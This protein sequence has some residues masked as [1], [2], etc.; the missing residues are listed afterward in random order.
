MIETDEEECGRKERRSQW[1]YIFRCQVR[2]SKETA[3]QRNYYNA[4]ELIQ[5]E[6]IGI[7][8]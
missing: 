5:I 8:I 2:I 1:P 3:R 4:R 7:S 6:G